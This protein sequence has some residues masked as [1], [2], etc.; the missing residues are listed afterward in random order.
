MRIAVASDHRGYAVKDKILALLADMGHVG[1]DAGPEDCQSVDYPE[2]AA[3]VAGSV[4]DGTVD[5]GILICGTGIGMC[6]AANKFRGVRAA[7]CHDDLTAEMSRLHNDANVLCLSADL[8]GDRL[9]NRMVEI[10][11]RTEFEGGRHARRLEQIA[12]LEAGLTSP[13]TMGA[14]R[15]GSSEPSAQ[16]ATLPMI[17][18]DPAGGPASV[19][20]S[21]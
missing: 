8:L 6:I 16:P 14:E 3:A 9:V 21:S 5:R 1:I 7:P 15:N 20:S 2:F 11:V 13:E 18:G 19:A 10:W 17:G 4:S 12:R